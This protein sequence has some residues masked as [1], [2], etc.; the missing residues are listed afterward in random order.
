MLILTMQELYVSYQITV[1][2]GFHESDAMTN[3][4]QLQYLSMLH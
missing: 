1:H 3:T 4:Y 2:S